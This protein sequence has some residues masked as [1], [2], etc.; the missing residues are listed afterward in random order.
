MSPLGPGEITLLLQ[1]LNNPKSLEKLA[2]LVY[3][4][5][6]QM[7]RAYLSHERAHSLQGTELVH[8]FFIRLGKSGLDTYENREQFFAAASKY[9]R[10][11][12][13]D[14]ARK[15]SAQKRPTV[16]NRVDLDQID[17]VLNEDP[18]LML[19]V[20]QAVTR[21]AE[22]DPHLARIVELRFFA[23]FT[24]EETGKILGMSDSSVRRDWR[25]A[26]NWLGGNL[27]DPS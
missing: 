26:K 5:L 22:F 27:G 23:G 11:I 19:A 6:R 1:D 2:P 13:I 15:R 16:D 9:M 14:L 3:N 25:L 18:M 10:H 20:D 8:E 7:A 21:L 17:V 24:S 12:L 4:Q